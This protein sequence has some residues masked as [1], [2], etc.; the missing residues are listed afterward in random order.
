MMKNNGVYWQ[1]LFI[2]SVLVLVA[3][4]AWPGQA[5]PAGQAGSDSQLLFIENVG[6]FS[7]DA[8]SRFVVPLGSLTLRLA[9]DALWLT[10]LETP[11][12]ELAEAV[13]SG[14]P[15]SD[16]EP[17]AGPGQ[18][19]H[20]KLSFTGA[21]P[22]PRLEPFNPLDL[23]LSYF[24]G[25][26]PAWWQ[27]DVRVW[28]GVRYVEV[29][30]GL[31]LE[32]TSEQGQ[33][34]QRLVLHEGSD[35]VTTQAIDLLRDIRYKVEGAEEVS[36]D[37]AGFLRLV[38][39]VGEV[40][41]PLLQLVTADGRPMAASAQAEVAP[42]G[43]IV[44]P[45]APAGQT[46]V[47]AAAAPPELVYAT[48]LGGSTVDSGQAVAVDEAGSAYIAGMTLSTD[49]PVTPGAFDTD[50]GN[51]I[52]R[53]TYVAKLAPDG[54][55]L[56]YATFLGGGDAEGIGAIAV[57]G[58]GHAYVTG[59]TRSSDFPTTPG[60][61]DTQL[62]GVIDAFVVKLNPSGTGL[63]Y[64]AYL[65]GSNLDQGD[66]LAIDEAGQ[67]Y[68]TGTTNSVDFPATPGA[69]DSDLDGFNDGF[70]AKVSAD[71]GSLIYATYLGG[72]LTDFGLAAAVDQAGNAYIT[73]IAYS[74]DFPTTPG[75]LATTRSGPSDAFVTKLA[76]DGSLVYSTYLGGSSD[77]PS[78][79]IAVDEAG[80]AYVLGEAWSAD[81]PTTPGAFD[82]GLDGP[83]DLY[84]AKLNPAGSALAYGSFIGGSSNDFGG[85]LAVDE[86]GSA[87]L[88]GYTVS[89]NFPRTVGDYS[90]LCPGCDPTVANT[91]TF[92]VKL[93]PGGATMLY[94]T[95][96]GGGSADNAHALALDGAGNVYVAGNTHSPDFPATSGA[97]DLD[98]DQGGDAFVFKLAVGDDPGPEPTPTPSPTPL[99]PH[100]CAPTALGQVTVGNGPRGVAVDPTRQRVYVANFGSNS[101][102]VINSASQTVLQTIG[103]IPS[104]NGL[105]YDPTHNR[106]WV[107]NYATD[108]LTPIQAN[109]QATV[110]TVLPAVSVGDGPWGVAYDPVHDDIYVANSLAGSVTVVDAATQAVTAT[111]SGSFSQPFHLAA[112]PLNGKVYVA[113]FGNNT[114]TILVNGGIHGVVQL[115]DSGRP[116]GIAVDET[117]ATIYVA[118][119]QTNRIVAIGPLQGQPDRFLGWA[120]FQRGYNPKRRL[121][122]RVIAVNPELGP[123][124][125]GGH[126]WATTNLA[127][128]SE[129][130]QALFIPKGWSSYFHVPFAVETGPK[131]ME[132]I[133]IDRPAGRVYITSGDFP[134][135]LSVIGDH[136]NVCPG[137]APATLPD[138][139]EAITVEVFSVAEFSRADVNADG[140]VD[141]LD[142]AYI[143]GR[144]DSQDA[145]ADL[146]QDGLVD[147]LDLVQAAGQYGRRLPQD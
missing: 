132:G 122:L 4:A 115:W 13:P 93:N 51:P 130:D 48:Y 25:S 31:D 67:V 11:P 2:G 124:F 120:S 65:G 70:A 104:A 71:G 58:G 17:P 59:V 24:N 18:G 107:S 105:A 74:A 57:D 22:E 95:L 32:I 19:V 82:T 110:F 46:P 97:F 41:L 106:I 26:D 89:A 6:Q 20:L 39:P 128:G 101:L 133:A 88:S 135:K 84:L 30:P 147:I 87:Y 1:W 96:V 40:S 146:N 111:L 37:E 53:Q 14:A 80:S 42:A 91:E 113:N 56:V 99:P 75:A 92:V 127:D 52:F 94:G 86:F 103:D 126:L 100:T 66:G 72:L 108:T 23:H 134:G 131:P 27:P 55:G 123:A 98:L 102:S 12:A 3:L 35:I 15:G 49:F 112:D 125:D 10:L 76:G 8:Q 33:L 45:F 28:G 47:E 119:I 79:A 68:L 116:Y 50:T 143:A 69:V 139:N 9:E 77:D 121:P 21:N 85:G 81:F 140:Q 90:P 54:S 136:N 60:A 34:V 118:T 63:V 78:L 64:S 61:F 137:L 144:Y 73:G 109:D 7:G 43:E 129:T 114:V 44:A 29:Y 62:D 141:I 142:L 83:N 38:T 138:P 5:A 117:R 145:S 36:L 16:L